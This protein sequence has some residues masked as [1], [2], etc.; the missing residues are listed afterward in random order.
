MSLPPDQLRKLF[1]R[2][3]RRGTILR[4]TIEF[5]G[6]TG[7]IRAKY[8]VVVSNDPQ[9]AD[10]IVFFIT[11]SQ[12]AAYEKNAVFKENAVILAPKTIA[13]LPLKTAINCRELYEFPRKDVE[14]LVANGEAAIVADLP[15]PIVAQ[16]DEIVRKSKLISPADKKKILGG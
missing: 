2:R 15:D 9:N 13:E 14:D 11:T 1:S 5:I 12:M 4:A 8:I 10:P 16:I 7:N 6:G 3:V